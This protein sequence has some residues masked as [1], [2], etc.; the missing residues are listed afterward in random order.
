MCGIVGVV[1]RTGVPDCSVL[2]RM[3]D[4]LAHRGPDGHGLWV[5]SDRSV[6]LGHRRLAIIDL[7][8]AAAQPMTDAS[9]DLHIVFNG[10]L[11]NYRE[12]REE[13]DGHGSRWRTSSDT[14]VVLEAYR[15]WGNECVRRFRGMFAFGIYDAARRRLFMARDRA[16]EK[17]LF[18]LRQPHRL[19]FASELKA[20]F[21]D[22]DV[23]RTL[24]TEALEFFLAYG[25]VPSTR[26][27][28]RGI[29]KLAAG[30]AASYD[31]GTGELSVWPY[32]QLPEPGSRGTQT[33]HELS[34]ELERLLE[35]AVRRQLHADVPVG[36][37]LSGGIDSSLVTALASRVS[38]RPVRTFT[39][40]FPGHAAFDEAPH[41]RRI[42]Q[43]FGTAHTE[44]AAD[45]SSVDLLPLLARQYD[46]PIAD[47]SII[48]S[49][50][51]AREVRRHA[52]VALGGDGAD[53][54]FGGYPHYSWL[55]RQHQLRRWLPSAAR[56]ACGYLAKR[57]LPFG[58]R[59]RNH[60]IGLNGD[61][62]N[63][64]AHVNLYF[65]YTA[66]RRLLAPGE[67]TRRVPVLPEVERARLCVAQHDVVRQGTEADFH[68]TLTD[69]YLVKIDRASMLTGLELRAPFLDHDVIEFAF[70][71][72]PPELRATAKSLKVL[73]KLLAKR[74]L[75]TDAVLE[76]KQGLTMPLDEWLRGRWGR[77]V[78]DVLRQ[79]D[80]RLF[81]R[82]VIS[83][84]LRAQRRGYRNSGRLF[85]LT[86][87]EL[88]RREYQIQLPID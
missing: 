72:V 21:A 13:L 37:L 65:D 38:D 41:A 50:L 11:Y 61:L 35:A 16:G 30:H 25:Y 8:E 68:T 67:A 79:A 36:V 7:S 42:A 62:G 54:L 19:L 88:W 18:Y 66:R 47:S 34:E 26:C 55:I 39:V 83:E 12:L 28:L 45:E 52:T 40:T 74:L 59:G 6:A 70:G 49:Y 5:A 69:G 9:G 29:S 33:P 77:Y 31:C 1:S 51:V 15:R 75:P 4:T 82:Q 85:A 86:V 10:E 46:E 43:H 44:L 81:D 14:E 22:P 56:L 24:D 20:L 58:T 64:V 84:L 17:P 63:A 87:F 80:H 78:E 27:I 53:E 3:R 48:P 76:R 73:P 32:W 57:V 71:R 23:P 60:L 2:G